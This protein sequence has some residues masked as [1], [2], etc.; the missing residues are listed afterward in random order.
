[1]RL[2]RGALSS[3]SDAGSIGTAASRL[4]LPVLSLVSSKSSVLANQ[5]SG[6]VTMFLIAPKRVFVRESD[7]RLFVCLRLLR[8]PSEAVGD[9]I[10]DDEQGDLEISEQSA[11]GH[12]PGCCHKCHMSVTNNKKQRCVTTLLK[13][14]H[15]DQRER[16]KFTSTWPS[17]LKDEASIGSD[18]I[19]KTGGFQWDNCLIWQQSP[20]QSSHLTLPRKYG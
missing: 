20:T 16:K 15:L 13:C 5:E 3:S 14:A 10:N 17:V 8:P 11:C 12:A 19:V 9:A 18:G 1:M 6:A 7:W 4:R 2:V